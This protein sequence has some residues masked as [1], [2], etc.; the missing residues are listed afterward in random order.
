M[1]RTP[2]LP[3]H[4]LWCGAPLMGGATKHQ[5]DCWLTNLE[6]V[7]TEPPFAGTSPI[8]TLVNEH[9]EAFR[10][11]VARMFGIPARLFDA[12]A[13]CVCRTCGHRAAAHI[14][15]S[16]FECGREACWS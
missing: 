11:E 4:C 8:E 3:S 13:D 5:A 14:G 6:I 7:D 1:T 16:C 2:D 10:R 15:G 12:S 9:R